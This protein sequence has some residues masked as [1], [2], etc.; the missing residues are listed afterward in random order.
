MVL[1]IGKTTTKVILNNVTVSIY[2]P[3]KIFGLWAK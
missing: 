1:N 2:G 3:T